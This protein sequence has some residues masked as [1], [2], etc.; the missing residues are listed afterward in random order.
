MPFLGNTPAEQYRTIVKQT[1]T[2][3]GSTIYTLDHSVTGSNDLEVF[4]NNV[5]Q[6]PG[7]AYTASGTAITFLDA[8][9]S[10]DACY[11]V[12]QGRS[13]AL[14]KSTAAVGG[15]DDAVFYENDNVVT[16]NYTLASG[17]NAMTTGPV[18]IQD[19]VNV[20]ISDG[21]RLVVL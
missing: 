10:T 5:R 14:G 17:K 21:S 13:V 4:I 8:V 20:T 9:Q 1:I 16:V 7:V 11:I 12:Y 6:E 15:G 18:F 3:N 2:G 19:G